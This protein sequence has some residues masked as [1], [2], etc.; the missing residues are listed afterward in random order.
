MKQE[1]VFYLAHQNGDIISSKQ[2]VRYI[3]D[4]L[5]DNFDFYYLDFESNII[6]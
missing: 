3:I 6:K 5:G 4:Q 2:Y 1:V